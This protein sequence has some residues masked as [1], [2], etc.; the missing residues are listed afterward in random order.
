MALAYFKRVLKRPVV[1]GLGL[2]MC[3]GLMTAMALGLSKVLGL[4]PSLTAGMISWHDPHRFDQRR[5]SLQPLHGPVS[6][7]EFSLK[8][9]NNKSKS[10]QNF[11][12]RGKSSPTA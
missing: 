3:Y 11:P 12:L 1:V 6:R 8:I 2:F 10:P 4:S 5:P 7:S 9:M